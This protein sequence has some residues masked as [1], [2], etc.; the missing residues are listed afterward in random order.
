LL[1]QERARLRT[2]LWRVAGLTLN[3]LIK[4][5]FSLSPLCLYGGTE[6]TESHI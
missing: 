1:E 5:Q 3:N 2:L 6:S 4:S